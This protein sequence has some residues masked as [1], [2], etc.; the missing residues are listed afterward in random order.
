MTLKSSYTLLE[1]CV[2]LAIIT[3]L[4][5]LGVPM[6]VNHDEYTIL[7]ELEKLEAICMYLHQRAI[8]TQKD[9]ELIIKTQQNIY[10][11]TINAHIALFRLPDTINFGWLPSALGPPGNPIAPITQE[12]SFPKLN[13][14]NHS[15]VV[16]FISNGQF[17]PGTLYLTDRKR[18]FMGAL[19]CSISRVFYIRKYLYKS[20]Q[21]LVQAT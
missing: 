5:L 1:L 18:R 4:C 16:K 12:C 17:Y 13:G 10:E 3:L 11:Y 8:A 21:W 2:V 15:H 14:Q 9:H 20:G 6:I 7:R 19:T